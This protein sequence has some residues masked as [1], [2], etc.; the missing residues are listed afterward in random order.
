MNVSYRPKSER[1][2]KQTKTKNKKPSCSY[3][4]P[5]YLVHSSKSF[6]WLFSEVKPFDLFRS[7]ISIR[8]VVFAN[9][10]ESVDTFF[11]EMLTTNIQ[12]RL[13]HAPLGGG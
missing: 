6:S 8:V 9:Q 1:K 10:K 3:E 2:E 11:C 12:G 4:F 13:R 5:S 7:D